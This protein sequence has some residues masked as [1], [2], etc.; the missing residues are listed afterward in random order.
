[1]KLLASG[2]SS[3]KDPVG[4]LKRSDDFTLVD[5]DMHLKNVKT[6]EVFETLL[7]SNFQVDNFYFYFIFV[8]SILC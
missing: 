6:E 7:L 2:L 4:F 3:F 8:G 1:M 5:D